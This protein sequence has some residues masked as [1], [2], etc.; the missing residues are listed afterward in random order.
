MFVFVFI[1]VDLPAVSRSASLKHKR[2]PVEMID[3]RLAFPA[4]QRERLFPNK[5]PFRKASSPLTSPFFLPFSPL[6]LALND[7]KMSS[8]I[9]ESYGMKPTDGLKNSL[10]FFYDHQEDFF[11]RAIW[12]ES[13][14]SL[15]GV[16]CFFKVSGGKAANCGCCFYP[17]LLYLIASYKCSLI[18]TP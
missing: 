9:G 1:F 13:H 14:W 16:S 3:K 5:G 15:S 11:S 2:F 8:D 10:S 18:P 12:C 17:S 7:Y 6:L 4:L